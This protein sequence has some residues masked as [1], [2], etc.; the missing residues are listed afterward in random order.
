MTMPNTNPTPALRSSPSI[1]DLSWPIVDGIGLVKAMQGKDDLSRSAVM[2]LS[3]HTAPELKV[4]A[5]ALGAVDYM[6]KPFDAEELMA[7]VARILATV[8]R[9]SELRA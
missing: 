1:L 8:A 9:E 4:R 2:V 6:T 5:L 7:R 3:G